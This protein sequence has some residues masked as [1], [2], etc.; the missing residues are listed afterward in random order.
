LDANRAAVFDA[1]IDAQWGRDA[2]ANAALL[3]SVLAANAASLDAGP[4]QQHIETIKAICTQPD[5]ESMIAAI[6]A[7]DSDDVWLSNAKA[8]LA[9]G[10]PGSARLAYELQQ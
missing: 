1:L 4:L 6:E 2:K 10:A 5:L 3:S 7:I 9:S 8:T